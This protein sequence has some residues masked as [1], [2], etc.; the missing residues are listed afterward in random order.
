MK[1]LVIIL[2]VVLGSISFV[3]AQSRSSRSA[4][5]DSYGVSSSTYSTPKYTNY[6]TTYKS[7][8]SYLTSQTY[9]TPKSYTT[10]NTTRTSFGNNS[11]M[12]GTDVFSNGTRRSSS[13]TSSFDYGGSRMTTTNY[14]DNSGNIKSSRTRVKNYGW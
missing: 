5:S 12:S 11:Y 1:K 9:S 6:N 14:Y 7:A 3:S 8:D 2:A 13:R 10:V 4:F